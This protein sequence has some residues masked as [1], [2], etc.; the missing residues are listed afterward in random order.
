MVWVEGA[1]FLVQG[2]DSMSNSIFYSRSSLSADK[3]DESYP[4]MTNPQGPKYL[5]GGILAQTIVVTPLLEAL[6]STI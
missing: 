6:H 3:N 1:R 2:W 4:A 5:D